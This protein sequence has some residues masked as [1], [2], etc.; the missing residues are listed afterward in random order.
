MAIT[1]TRRIGAIAALGGMMTAA[2]ALLTGLPSAQA[3]ELAQ[4]KANQALL[5]QRLNQLEQQAAVGAAP[6]PPGAPSLAGSF[7]RSILIPGTN[8]SM[9]IGGF[10]QL[11][12]SYWFNGGNPND[13]SGAAPPLTGAPIIAGLPLRQPGPLP[14][15]PFNTR[16]RSNGIFRMQADESR[17]FIETR[18]P[19]SYGEA[20]T[21]FEF[22]MF[23]CAGSG[24][25]TCSGLN[26][27][28]NGNVPRFRLGYGTLGPFLAGQN[29]GATNDLEASPTLFD[30]GGDVGILGPGRGPQIRYTGELPYGM[31]FIVSAYQPTTSL[32]TPDGAFMQDSLFGVPGATRRRKAA[33]RL[34]RPRAGFPTATL[35]CNSDGR[36]G[37][38]GSTP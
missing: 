26:T 11:D 33:S 14:A 10:V 13:T 6:V 16:T 31:S 18:T 3:D 17:F 2:A 30:F 9:Q 32:F 19:T 12:A 29:Y 20:I 28:T 4:L 1:T 15:G 5:Q 38:S 8:T 27:T 7:P 21:H 25:P 36:G 34:I 22:D 24:G 23:G 37:K 35:S